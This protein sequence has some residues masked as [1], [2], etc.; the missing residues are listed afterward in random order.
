M[1]SSGSA[2]AYQGDYDAI[3]SIDNQALLVWT[4][5]RGGNYGSYVGFFPDYAMLVLPASDTLLS[6]NDSTT[7]SLMI[8]SVKLYSST[9]TFSY[10]VSPTPAS[11]NIIPVYPNGNV[12]SAFPDT[13][14][15]RIK[16][17]GSVTPGSY[18][19]TITGTGPNGTPVHKRNLNLLVV[20]NVRTLNLTALIEGMY[21]GS[22]TVSDT[23][24]V[25]L[26]NNVSPFTL[27]ETRKP[28]MNTSG[29]GSASFS[30]AADGLPYFIVLKHRNALETWSGTPQQFT[31]GSLSYDFTT[32]SAKAFGFNMVKKGTKWCIYSGDINRDGVVDL[33]DVV[34]VDIDNINFASGYRATDI[35]GDNIIDLSDVVVV[36]NNNLKFITKVFPTLSES[37][38]S[39]G[40]SE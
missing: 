8:P 3:T 27:V 23:M 28:V 15:M 36:D 24:T 12:I 20:P 16:T 29:F 34:A 39:K 18:T 37:K 19:V 10:T 26:R 22:T 1:S 25:E 33:S 14:E 21:N 11:G 32:D 6:S 35:S 40:N 13:L 7:I 31:G 17:I 38:H 2:P 30:S 9:V 5:F 4:D